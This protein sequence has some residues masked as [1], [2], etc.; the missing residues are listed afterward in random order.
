P[1]ATNRPEGRRGMKKGNLRVER[2]AQEPGNERI[3]VDEMHA[4]AMQDKVAGM[5]QE[6]LGDMQ[7]GSWRAGGVEE[8][9]HVGATGDRH[10]L[11]ADDIQRRAKPV[12][13]LAKLAA[14]IGQS[15]NRAPTERAPR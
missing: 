5:A 9:P 11:E 6:P 10:T 15:G 13:E 12:D 14:V 4:S 2:A 7:G 3:A 8:V 1:V